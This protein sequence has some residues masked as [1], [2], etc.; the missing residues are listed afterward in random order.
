LSETHAEVEARTPTGMPRWVKVLGIL[1][2]VAVLLYGVAHFTGIGHG[3]GHS[4]GNMQMQSS[5][6]GLQDGAQQGMQQP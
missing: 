5:Q 1:I 6:Q 2:I 3:P 4:M